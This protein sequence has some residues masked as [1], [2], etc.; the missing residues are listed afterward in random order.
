METKKKLRD[1]LALV[2]SERETIRTE[3]ET[4]SATLKTERT[5]RQA[6]LDLIIDALGI[7][8]AYPDVE[9]SRTFTDYRYASSRGY[10]GYYNSS[11]EPYERT[12][13]LTDYGR[14]RFLADVKES[15][16][17]KKGAEALARL[18]AALKAAK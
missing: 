13:T 5:E 2:E 11:Y 10:S 14:H 12:E 15:R 9:T 17:A 8:D 3:K 7:R 18:T 1:T 6:D 4:T 16:K